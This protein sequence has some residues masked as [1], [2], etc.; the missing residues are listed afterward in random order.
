ME[1]D[2]DFNARALL[3]KTLILGVILSF[4]FGCAGS[5]PEQ[6]ST[7]PPVEEKK[8]E[9]PK[10]EETP[11]PQP[12]LEPPVKPAPPTASPSASKPSKT[13]PPSQPLP[14]PLPSL[15][16]TK[17]VWNTVNLREGPGLNYRV[18]GN[19]KKG[20]SLSI[21]EDRGNWLRV[22]LEDG[23]EAWV[24]K[25]ATSDAPKSPPAATPKPKPM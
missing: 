19:A 17:V 9:Q 3:L 6:K 16:T 8:I 25:A 15:R 23:K 13:P 22:R 1:K 21:L 20:T 18:I 24:S 11:G 14:S 5:K 4:A 2:W 10:K 12:T 7:P